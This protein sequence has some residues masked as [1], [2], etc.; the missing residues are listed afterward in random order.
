VPNTKK[1]VSDLSKPGPH[2]V[3]RGDL[4]LAGLPGVVY[5]P[6][7]GLNLP[8]VAFAHGWLTGPA[9]YDKTLRHLASWGIVVAAPGTERGPIPSHIG[10]ANDLSVAL[11]IC[12]GVRLGPGQISVRSDRLGVVGHG[13]GGGVAVLAAARRPEIAAVASLFPAPT[14]PTAESVAGGI[15][16][17]ALVVGSPLELVSMASDPVELTASLGGHAVLRSVAKSSR[18]GMVEGRRLLGKIGVGGDFEKKTSK[19]VRA[20]LTGFL[21]FHLTGDDTYSE[22]SDAEAEIKKTTVIDPSEPMPAPPKKSGV[23][24]VS[25]LLGR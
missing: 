20:L 7:E 12:T 4:A 13:M 10:F 19:T 2:R 11:D 25:Q 6:A 17:P 5:T 14:A 16:A 3:L 18:D 22:F 1:L 24:Q 15:T 8:A 9:N 21:L 23:R